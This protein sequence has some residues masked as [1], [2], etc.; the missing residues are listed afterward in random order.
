MKSK[1]IL[2][3]VLIVSLFLVTACDKEETTAEIP[4]DEA[5]TTEEEQVEET[6]SY[7]GT[8]YL[9]LT[10]GSLA[11]DGSGTITINED[12]SC[13]YIYGQANYRCQSYTVNDNNICMQVTEAPSDICLVL[14][15]SNNTLNSSNNEKYKK[16][17]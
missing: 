14:T 10:D 16:E 12:G 8:Y 1:F 9:E 11:K 15:D 5:S 2:L 3:C 17:K 4:T 13:T 7:I 6:A